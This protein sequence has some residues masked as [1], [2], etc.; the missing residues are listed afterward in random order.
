VVCTH[1][2]ATQKGD[3]IRT[4]PARR[5]Q[6]LKLIFWNTSYADGH[7][8]IHC[9]C[10]QGQTSSRFYKDNK[11]RLVPHVEVAATTANR[12]RSRPASGACAAAS[13]GAS[14]QRTRATWLTSVSATR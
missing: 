7:F 11:G 4:T 12:S 5:Q 1:G 2:V 13:G 6:L 9:A 8:K 3:G 10:G 14:I